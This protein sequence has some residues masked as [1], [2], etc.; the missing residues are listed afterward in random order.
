M[1]QGFPWYDSLWLRQYVAA[2]Q[3]IERVCPER[4]AHFEDAFEK[5]RTRPDFS[6]CRVDRVFDEPTMASV[7]EA[8]NSISA[9]KLELHEARSFRRF[10]VHDQ[11]YFTELQVA[12]E[13]LVSGLVGEAVESNYNFLSMY[14]NLGTC[15]VHMDS[16]Q[17]KWTLDLCL[18]QSAPW[19][20]HFSQVVPW[21]EE[22][23][24]QGDDWENQIK[25]TPGIRFESHELEPGEAV[26][27]SGSSQWHYR[28]QMS[29]IGPSHF[30]NLLFFHFVPRGT[31]ELTKPKNWPK[32]FDIQELA[33]V[34]A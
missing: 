3:V 5:L 25:R 32:I 1:N 9:D 31:R 29:T 11:P 26:I 14:S 13:A 20:I 15:S 17:A 18:D 21:P 33:E 4:L 22:S 7:R 8:V 19:P 12:T 2:K 24:F 28:D 6:A 30:C 10:V 16:P 23:S 34:V 27:F